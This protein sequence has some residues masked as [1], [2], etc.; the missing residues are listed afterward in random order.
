MAPIMHFQ[1]P[2]RGLAHAVVERRSPQA[3]VP[4]FWLV[5]VD[6]L[7]RR[8]KTPV[9]LGSRDTVGSSSGQAAGPTPSLQPS[10]EAFVGLMVFLSIIAIGTSLISLHQ[11]HESLRGNAYQV[12]Q[13]CI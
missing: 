9:A 12:S 11:I 1:V 4:P 8:A 3:G 10:I 5:D 6:I 7:S 13:R 2:G